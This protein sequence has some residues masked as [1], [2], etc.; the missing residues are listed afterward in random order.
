[1]ACPT[2]NKLEKIP[3]T[4]PSIPHLVAVPETLN[5]GIVDPSDTLVDTVTLLNE[6]EATLDISGISID[7]AAFTAASTT[8]IG[9]LEAGES[10]EMLISYQPQN[11]EDNGWL[12]VVSDDPQNPSL[13]VP[14]V[15]QGAIPLLIID[16]PILDMGW[17]DLNETISSEIT[18]R[19]E[20]VADLNVSQALL[21]G[22]EF[23]LVDVSML[24]AVLGPGEEL[25]LGIT[26]SPFDYGEHQAQLWVESNTPGG[27]SQ[28]LIE[29]ACA[30]TPVAV[31]SV[32]PEEIYP[33]YET[34]TWIGEDS[35]DTSGGLITEYVWTL[36]EKPEG[37]ISYIPNG[38]PNRP[39]FSP[40]LAGTY[41]GQLVV[42]N[43]WGR[44]SEPCYAELEAIPKESLWVEM[45]WEYPADDMDLHIIRPN[46]AI[47]TSGDCYYANCVG[48][49]LDW[50]I[51]G[52]DIDDPSLDI[53]D[54]TGVGP[55]NT[56]ILEPENG[57]FQI[58]VHDFPG[59]VFNDPN[60]VW[61]RIY[62]S[63]VMVWEDYKVIS[64]EN[65]YTTFATVSWPD[66]AV[67]PQ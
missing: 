28:A 52:L 63:G 15:G 27:T 14:L 1:M 4:N 56:N 53:D 30:P 11:L 37:S 36:Y 49:F 32:D 51:A 12:K 19:N 46:G 40:D 54:I 41:I 35:Y 13:Y 21:V 7:G 45:W 9:L 55:E 24:P 39:D 29:G 18:L 48:G 3:E 5:F 57:T 47:E 8:P 34:A 66:G 60:T 33:H 31:C 58:L 64:G 43:E 23:S 50:G 22:V 26:Y 44:E 42:H 20:G 10:T 2:E 38:G 65:S 16:P 17:A 62:V 25:E 61:V 67:T 6:G 59:S